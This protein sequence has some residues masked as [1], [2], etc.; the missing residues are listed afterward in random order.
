MPGALLQIVMK[1][2]E[3][4]YLTTD[5]Q[6][7]FYKIIYRRHTIF[8]SESQIQKFK[9]RANFGESVECSISKLG[10]LISSIILYVRLPVI[11]KFTNIFGEIDP[12]KKFAWV[13]NIAY[14]IINKISIEIGG[15]L[16]NPI[17]GKWLYI[18]EAMTN[19]KK[20]GNDILT[21]NIPKLYSFSNGKNGYDLYIYVDA[22]FSRAS[23]LSLP[24]VSLSKSNVKINVSFNKFD[25]CCIIEPTN[26][27]KII[28]SICLF[29]KG[30]TIYQKINN[31]YIYGHYTDFD[32]ATN[33]L[34]YSN[35]QS[36][37]SQYDS[38][39][40]NLPIFGL[41]SEHQVIPD[42]Q[43][44]VDTLLIPDLDD[45]AVSLD[46]SYLF[47]EY[48]YLGKEEREKFVKTSQEYLITQ[49]QYNYNNNIVTTNYKQRLSLYN[50]IVS[51]YWIVW[52][53]RLE[54]FYEEN[55]EP[56][57]IEGKLV[58]D[59]VDRMQTSDRKYYNYYQ[60]YY[61]HK[62]GP[63]DGIYSYSISITP[64]SIQSA[65]TLN[66]SKLELCE[67]KM[68]LS[69]VVSVYNPASVDFFAQSL[70]L[71]RIDSGKAILVW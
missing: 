49:T 25:N 27:I 7:T 37:N 71:L 12:I 14:T 55:S 66:A 13:H 60:P 69:D 34:Y 4:A 16:L 3:D 15:L 29:T 5:P 20:N 67:F 38:F 53:N 8:A 45:M 35:M 1:G 30:E 42:Q 50:P 59:G 6:V 22:W 19:T 28:D 31:E 68:K 62:V 18:W 10:D 40:T 9:T 63:R 58:V 23:S 51:I 52:L 36:Q 32:Y 11:P 54:K 2:F 64:E 56:L 41:T 46:D 33:K 44:Q 61:H 17:Y 65:S 39:V 57:F 48:I 24:L 26:S 43:T 21:G 47:V 70:N